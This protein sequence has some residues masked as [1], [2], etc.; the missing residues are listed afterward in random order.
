MAMVERYDT[1]ADFKVALTEELGGILPN[2]LWRL[3]EDI[4]FCFAVHE[5]CEKGDIELA[6][7]LERILRR[8]GI[9]EK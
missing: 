9:G 4:L 5:P 6:V 8:H 7:D 1:W 3:M 2:K